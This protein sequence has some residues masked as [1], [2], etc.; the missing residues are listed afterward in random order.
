[1]RKCLI[2]NSLDIA[3]I[4]ALV[5]VNLLKGLVPIVFDSEDKELQ[6]ISYRGTKDPNAIEKITNSW[7]LEHH[8]DFE[9]DSLKIV[10]DLKDDIQI[11]RVVI[12]GFYN[13]D[14]D[15]SLQ[16]YKIYISNDPKAL[17]NDENMVVHYQNTGKCIPNS[18]RN[19]CDQVFDLEDYKGRYF[20][21][22]FLKSCVVDDI[23]RI[24]H[25]GIYNHK[26]TEQLSFCAKNFS[27]NIL[28]GKIPSV[29]GSYSKDLTPLTDGICFDENKR[30]FLNADTEFAFKFEDSVRINSVFIVGSSSAIDNCE[31]S[32]AYQK[33]DLFLEE[34]LL[35]FEI[36]IVPS[37]LGSAAVLLFADEIE[38][39]F[40]GFKFKN[41][42]YIDQLGVQ[43]E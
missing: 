21:L 29:V 38:A 22:Q 4:E 2:S 40:I 17:F 28:S 37:N 24:S 3:E 1:M 20:A 12:S 41:G 14:A 5:G 32:V 19:H 26:I 39:N 36:C 8:V 7:G 43:S 15:Y 6:E 33:E 35:E 18:E 23:A 34:N 10:Y 27:Q 9:S 11:D 30:I 31:I 13:G 25:I 16:S 42:D